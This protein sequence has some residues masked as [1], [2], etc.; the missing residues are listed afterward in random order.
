MYG[1]EQIIYFELPPE[2]YWQAGIF[3]M[4][5]ALLA[6]LYPAWKAISLR[7]VEAIRKI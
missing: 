3:V 1:L 7:P 5:T 6:S 2:T 4:I